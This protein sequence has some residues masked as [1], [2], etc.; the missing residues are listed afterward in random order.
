MGR[1]E[2]MSSTGKV[3]AMGCWATFIFTYLGVASV[4]LKPDNIWIP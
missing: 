2:K 4:F 1:E 3:S